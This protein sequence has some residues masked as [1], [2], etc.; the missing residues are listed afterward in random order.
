M[1]TLSPF[2]NKSTPDAR[3]WHESTLFPRHKAQTGTDQYFP[4]PAFTLPLLRSPTAVR[5][6]VLWQRSESE[7]GDDE[8]ITLLYL[9]VS[10]V[11]A[12]QKTT[13]AFQSNNKR[14]HL[15][16]RQAPLGGKAEAVLLSV[17]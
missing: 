5:S 7:D 3:N 17:K 8:E 12:K 9:L 11:T 2:A 4:Y 14:S 6:Q 15:S 16:L 13:I 1:H 10:M